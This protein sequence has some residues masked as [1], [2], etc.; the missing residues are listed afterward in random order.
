MIAM[1]NELHLYLWAYGRVRL[2]PSASS[3]KSLGVT[4]PVI[5]I[6][7]SHKTKNNFD[8]PR[9]RKEARLV[10]TAHPILNLVQC[11]DYRNQLSS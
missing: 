8:V 10:I 11:M 6:V 5:I 1:T 9:A 2:K 3:S 7:K 4:L